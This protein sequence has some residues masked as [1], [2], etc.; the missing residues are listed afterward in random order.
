VA[1]ALEKLK[2]DPEPEA[3]FMRLANG[4]AP[5]YN[6]QTAVDAEH[7]IIVAQQVTTEANDQRSLLPMAE[8]AK[9]ALGRPE[10]LNVVAD[11][12]YSNGEHAERCESQG[13]LP[14]AP[15]NRSINNKGDGTLFDRRL[16]VYDEKTDT[17]CCPAG[18]TL[19]R[20]QLSRK[21]RCVVYSA[22]AQVCGACA[23]KNR[24]TSGS[25][26]WIMRHLHDGALQRMNQRTTAQL[27]RLRRCTAERPFAVLK[28]VILGN[29][30][31]LLRGRDGAQTEISLATLA[32][33][34]KTMIHVL[35]GYK[36]L[37]ALTN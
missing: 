27:M 34:L 24:C 19:V 20:R 8:A 30:R 29:A 7:A 35:G 5:A 26:R 11:G 16:F 36:L 18:Q 21:D 4:H 12:G 14:H 33:N 17:F 23:M 3:R 1:A 10:R 9:Q 6:V 31:L 28:H 22:E 32:Y 13:I 37:S 2:N 15:T 25:R